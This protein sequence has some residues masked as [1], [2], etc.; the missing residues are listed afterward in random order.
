MERGMGRGHGRGHG[1]GHKG[2]PVRHRIV[3]HGSVPGPYRGMQNPLKENKANINT[4]AK[5]F[6]ITPSGPHSATKR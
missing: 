4:G 5:L 2:N 6:L 1:P 3:R